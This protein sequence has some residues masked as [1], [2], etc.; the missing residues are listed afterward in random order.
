M[1][2]RSCAKLKFHSVCWTSSLIYLSIYRSLSPNCHTSFWASAFITSPA[3]ANLRSL[4]FSKRER[5]TINRHTRA[6]LSIYCI[7]IRGDEIDIK[8]WKE[9]LIHIY[10]Y[11]CSAV[12]SRTAFLISFRIVL[13]IEIPSLEFA[14][15]D[16]IGKRRRGQFQKIIRLPIDDSTNTRWIHPLEWWNARTIIG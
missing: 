15:R 9:H 14:G 5:I 6:Y 2:D 3:Y 8:I 7:D 10:V 13:Y 12:R 11:F 4:R 16:Q 1:R